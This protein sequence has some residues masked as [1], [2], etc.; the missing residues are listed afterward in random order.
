MGIGYRCF[1]V[2]GDDI[3]R[4]SQKAFS[5]FYFLKQP[6]LP[7][8]AHRT[9]VVAMVFYEVEQRIPRGVIR[10]D[11]TRLKVTAQG[12]LDEDSLHERI[13][14]RFRYSETDTKIAALPAPKLS[15]AAMLKMRSAIFG[16]A[17]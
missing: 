8:Y 17:G 10:T 14:N 6:Q 12:A 1:V 4:L 5:A 13:G 16:D 2:E 7:Q 11:A 15:R 9:V 3:T